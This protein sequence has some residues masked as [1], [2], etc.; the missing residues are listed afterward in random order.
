VSYRIEYKNTL[1]DAW[2]LL[3][4]IAGNGAIRTFT[5]AG[6]LPAGSRFYRIVPQ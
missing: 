6:P 4:T 1:N 2:Q 3:T 5:D